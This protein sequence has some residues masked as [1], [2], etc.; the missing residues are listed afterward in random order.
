MTLIDHVIGAM[1]DHPALV[2]E[3]VLSWIQVGPL[4][5]RVRVSDR[6]HDVLRL[7]L[8]SELGDSCPGRP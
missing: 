1:F 2:F 5:G 8:H 4:Q 3:T 6:D 7:P